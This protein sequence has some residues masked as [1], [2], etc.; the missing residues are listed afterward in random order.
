LLTILVAAVVIIGCSAIVG[1]GLCVVGGRDLWAWWAPAVGFAALLTLGGILI[2]APGHSK[3]TALGIAAATVGSLLSPRVRTAVA[4]AL[5]DGLPVAGI[6]LLVSLLPFLVSGRT[7]ILGASINNDSGAHLGTAWWL[8]H[9]QGP[10]P[11]GALGGPLALVG[12]PVGPHGLIDALSQNVVSLVRV[13]DA[14]IIVVGPLTA[15][16]ALGALQGAPR[17]ARWIA[18]S[19]VGLCY[20]AVSFT[21]QAAF[22]ET[23]EAMWVIAVVLATRDLV[24]T[25]QPDTRWRA[26]IPLGIMI[27]G[28]IW[29]YSYGGLLWTT[30]AAVAT[31]L[32]SAPW[33]RIWH[34]VPGA[35]LGAAVVIAPGL[36]DIE[37]FRN[38][39]FNHEVGE[40]NLLHALS[41]VEGL[42]VW[43]NYDFRWTPQPLWPTAIFAG[44]A[45]IAA[46]VAVYRLIKAHQLALPAALIPILGAYAYAADKRSIYL[47][48]K[49]LTVAGP[50]IALTIAVGLLLRLAPRRRGTALALSLLAIGAAAPAAVSSFMALREGRVGPEAH[51]AELSFL[52]PY[53]RNGATLFMP[54][55]DLVQWELVGIPVAQGRNFYAPLVAPL[56]GPKPNVRAGFL[57]FDDFSHDTLDQYLYAITT[58]TPYQSTP[59]RNWHRYKSTRSYIVWKR[60]GRTPLRYPTD[61]GGTPGRVLDCNSEVGRQRLAQ[62]GTGFALV[63]PTPVVGR[64]V[65]W[66][67]QTFL[68]GSSATMTLNVPRG[69]W[70]LSLAY[71]AGTGLDVRVGS[72]RTSMPATTDR[73]SPPYLVGTVTQPRTG[74]LTI[75]V[76]AK[77]LGAIGRLLGGRGRT[78]GLDSPSNQPLGPVALTRHGQHPRRVQPR[79][80]CGRYTDYV[81]PP[82]AAGQ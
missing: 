7:G 1:Q 46:I 51:S 29:V 55:D 5:P 40:G 33:R 81:Q 2:N 73:L 75:H 9:H 53:L 56:S 21:V 24:T 67:N 35:V 78:R 8:Q 76:R 63:W 4:S 25:V 42:G 28:T 19:L 49:A 16:V 82:Q 71:A 72:M 77:P 48:A 80:A 15:L 37:R 61:F 41:P 66:S 30:G 11:V 74:P 32:V 18:A 70:D 34:A 68:A 20:L 79:Q 13:F 36:D 62:A 65:L 14:L 27:G 3:T 17:A 10:P 39:P 44:I 58:N 26:G 23:M 43:F 57:D 64:S 50:L 45:G 6:T 69:R 60:H 31:A 38:S 22:K 59:P 47:G 52:K 12:Y 54:K